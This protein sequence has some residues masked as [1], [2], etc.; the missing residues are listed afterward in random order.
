MGDITFDIPGPGPYLIQ[1]LSPLPPITAAVTIDGLAEPPG[2]NGVV[3]DL[4][5]QVVELDGSEAGA[6]ADGLTSTSPGAT[7]EG[8]MI[9]H[10]SGD[11]ILFAFDASSGN[12]DDSRTATRR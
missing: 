5:A 10:F 1:P 11:G 6:G 9:E 8:P 4:P 3:V 7:V 2:E 12:D